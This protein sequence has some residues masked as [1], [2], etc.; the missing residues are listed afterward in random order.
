[1]IKNP[2]LSDEEHHRLLVEWNDT[3]TGYPRDCCIH[4]LF[5]GQV[6][7]TPDTVALVLEDAVVTYS[8]L[9]KR[10]NQLAHHLLSLGVGVEVVAGI[11]VEH[12]LDMIVAILG[13]LKAGGAYVPLDLKSPTERLALILNDV[14]ATVILT[15]ERLLPRI[16]PHAAHTVRLDADWAEIGKNSDEKPASLTVPENVAFVLYTSGSTGAPR[17]VLTN[18]GNLVSIYHAWQ[19]AYELGSR[20][21]SHCQTTN[22]SFAVFHAD[23]IRALCSGGKLTL[24]SLETVLTPGDLYRTMLDQVI[25]FAE[26]VPAVLRNVVRYSDESNR[27]LRL[28]RTLVV[29]SDR[30]YVG[31]HTELQEN[32]G[33]Q[34]QVIHSFGLTET[35]VDSAHFKGTAEVLRPG[36][37][38]PIGRPFPNVKIYILDAQFRPVPVGVSGEMF[39]G[40]PG[41]ARGY[42]NHPQLTANRFLP[43]PFSSVP[44]SRLYRTGDLA[45]YLPDGNI[46]FL[47]RRDRQVK[48]RGFRVE[49]GEVEMALRQH[50]DV[51]ESVVT[52]RQDETGEKR[53]MAYVVPS[54]TVA[55]AVDLPRYTLPNEL[56]IAYQGKVEAYQLYEKIFSK[57]IYVKHGIVINDGD[58]V[59]DVGANIG[60]FSLFVHQARDGISLYAFEPAPALFDILQV[61]MT[62]HGV[63]AELFDCGLSSETRSTQ[64][65]FY[66]NSSFLSSFQADEQD[67][68]ILKSLALKYLQRHLPCLTTLP[69][70][71][72]EL[73]D[74]R[75][76]AKTL[77]CHSKTLSD[78]IG[79]NNI[80]QIDLLKIS[81]PRGELGILEGIDN[82]DWKRIRQITLE[83][84]AVA[85]EQI[86]RILNLLEQRGYEAIMDQAPL[87]K[88]SVVY[89]IYAVQSL[90]G[91]ELPGLASRDGM[92]P[93]GSHCGQPASRLSPA[94]VPGP[95]QLLILSAETP[96]ALEAATTELARYLRQ[97]PD[98]NLADVAYSLH[99]DD[100]A[101]R[102][103]R[104][105][106]CH[107]LQEAVFLLE[108]PDA[109]EVMTGEQESPDR[110][111]AFMLPG[112]GVQY[113]GMSREVYLSEP[114]FREQ[115]DLCAR[116]LEP[117]LGY[118]LRDFLYPRQDKAELA[119]AQME[120]PSLAFPALFAV[121]YALAKL[122]MSWGIRPWAMIG[123]CFG[124]Y[125]AACLA[126]VFSLQDALA[127]AFSRGRL[128]ERLP[129]GAMLV[130]SLP[131]K[132]IRALLGE[133][134]S[135]AAINGPARCVVSGPPAAVKDIKALLAREGKWFFQL[136]TNVVEKLT[137]RAPRIPFISS[138]TGAWITDAE[139]TDPHYWVQHL[140]RMIRFADGI[141]ELLQ[142]PSNVLLEVGLGRTLGTLAERQTFDT[143]L[144]L[145]SLGYPYDQ[146]PDMVLLLRALS[147][148][149]LAGAKVD[150]PGF[151]TNKQ[152]QRVSIQLDG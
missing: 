129:Q 69:E 133:Q 82:D 18:H 92:A 128:F 35:T 99:V 71:A 127:L 60:L 64:F 121:E 145:G 11:Y 89:N 4:Q 119:L 142:E 88:G 25:D 76:E 47:G 55:Q 85:Q 120:R 59:V 100:E 14:R 22:F 77:D 61:N 74:E 110:R 98:L 24:C 75:F 112:G 41:L 84:Y 51:K 143:R 19:E 43:D 30:W 26:F 57:E 56:T 3:D 81:A 78:I 86:E 87:F 37:L 7:Q 105:L 138:V 96:S 126:G 65:T 93:T 66:S 124:E 8:A 32:C 102:Y 151:W 46:Q 132:E 150:W 94:D 29:G 2:F 91:N 109:R 144:I 70:H 20:A 137:L 48:V 38:V 134:L 52:V 49:L 21:T 83:V 50:P 118:D 146:R 9:D 39:I 23:W 123:H 54:R 6:E 5:E 27:P 33:P 44:G 1:M 28:S 16:A 12:S 95:S 31:E 115:V 80:D 148:L 117:L 34:S 79:E 125:A 114:V 68:Y 10:A 116:I 130:V 53:L 72:E 104:A 107:S 103:R 58:C 147:Q 111:I 62:L 106:V 73:I 17:G 108:R 40:G 113:I 90:K 63:D 13:I 122:W 97:N 42:L 36:H 101:S 136:P 131:E 15:Q 45:C 141:R 152:R 140:R 149:W 67:Q 139:A 135:L